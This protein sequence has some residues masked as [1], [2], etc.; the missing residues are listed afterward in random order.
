MGR[1]RGSF[2][3]IFRPHLSRYSCGAKCLIEKCANTGLRDVP[4]VQA[5]EVVRIYGLDQLW[6]GSDSLYLISL[7]NLIT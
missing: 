3:L 2:A 6:D 4:L 5:R 7:P 1:E